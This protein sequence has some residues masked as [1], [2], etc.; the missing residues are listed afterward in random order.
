MTTQ[1]GKGSAWVSR[2]AMARQIRKKN[3]NIQTLKKCDV[4]KT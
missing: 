3:K 2:Q 1:D 4:K